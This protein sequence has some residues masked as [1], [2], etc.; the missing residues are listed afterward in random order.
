M[1]I[2]MSAIHSCLRR[3][4]VPLF[5]NERTS[6]RKPERADSRDFLER[7][8]T[9]GNSG[10]AACAMS[11]FLCASLW[12][13][14]AAAIWMSRGWIGLLFS[15]QVLSAATFMFRKLSQRTQC[16]IATCTGT[17]GNWE[18]KRNVP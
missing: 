18:G 10:I 4:A 1:R 16:A 12:I 15:G 5:A 2:E 11:C 9:G 6:Y 8:V 3:I 17:A 14:L 13:S 7:R